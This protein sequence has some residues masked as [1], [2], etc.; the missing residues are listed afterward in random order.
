VHL[1]GR[2]LQLYV[3]CLLGTTGKIKPAVIGH[4][5]YLPVDQVLERLGLVV[6]QADMEHALFLSVWERNGGR[7]GVS[8]SPIEV[9]NDGHAGTFCPPHDTPLGQQIG[10]YQN[11]NEGY[12]FHQSTASI[13]SKG[14][15]DP[16]STALLQGPSRS[17]RC[18]VNEDSQCLEL[19]AQPV[20]FFPVAVR[21]GLCPLLHQP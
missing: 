11:D 2:I 6:S 1:P 19:P 18:V 21:S 20:G 15:T 8:S 4:A 12:D 13:G 9:F 17:F 7:R 3:S 16:G 5:D 10:P 14:K